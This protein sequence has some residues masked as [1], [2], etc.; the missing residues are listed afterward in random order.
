MKEIRFL[1]FTI[2]RNITKLLLNMFLNHCKIC[3]MT[4][5]GRIFTFISVSSNDPINLFQIIITDLIFAILVSIFYDLQKLPLP[6]SNAQHKLKKLC[7]K[8]INIDFE[9]TKG[10]CKCQW[11][12]HEEGTKNNPNFLMRRHTRQLIF[13]DIYEPYL[14]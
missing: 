6:M 9:K 2:H 7:L 11:H 10:C 1:I 14:L 5:V 12:L 3:N 13:K 8:L 4:F